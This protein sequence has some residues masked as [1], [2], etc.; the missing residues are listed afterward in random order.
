MQVQP[1]LSCR[2]AHKTEV[3]ED[4]AEEGREG[5]RG[6]DEET[7]EVVVVEAEVSV[8]KAVKEEA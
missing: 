3:V 6:E 5:N 1:L 7:A 2:K 4:E 8:E